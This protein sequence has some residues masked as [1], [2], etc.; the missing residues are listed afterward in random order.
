[1]GSILELTDVRNKLEDLSGVELKPGENPYCALID[2]CHDN[3][4]ESALPYHLPYQSH[5]ALA[6]C[7]DLCRVG[8]GVL[9]R[10]LARSE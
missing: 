7:E 8:K 9:I 2:A 1:M 6:V 10:L 5:F 3:P 4:V